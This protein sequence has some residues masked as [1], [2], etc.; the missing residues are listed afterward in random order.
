[1]TERTLHHKV[2]RMSENWANEN[3]QTIRTLMERTAIYRRAL[4]PISLVAGSLGVLSG[5]LAWRLGIEDP[6]N[7]IFWWIGTGVLGACI[8]FFQMRSQA[9]RDQ[10]AL[11]SPPTRRVLQAMS[12]T[13]LS[14]IIVSIVFLALDFGRDVGVTI[15]PIIW[16]LFFGSAL[17]SAGFFMKRGI[18]LLGWIF[19]ATAIVDLLLMANFEE[20]RE[21]TKI[22][23]FMMATVFGG[24]NL[25]YCFYLYATEKE[26]V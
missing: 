1:M 21:N 19:I 26:E 25:A 7:F 24:Y 3:L 17:H 18:R 4:A 20:L 12:P 5:A 14:G 9:V 8:G 11:F 15:L 22:S 2:S 23:H 6:R 16:M 10:E 13:F